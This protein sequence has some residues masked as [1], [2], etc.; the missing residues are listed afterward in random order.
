M[1]SKSKLAY[2]R[3]I[4]S[5]PVEEQYK[6]CLITEAGGKVQIHILFI[7]GN[8]FEDVMMVAKKEAENGKV[9][10]ILPEIHFKEKDAR[11][12]LLPGVKGQSNPDL[13]VDSSF[14][15]VEKTD[16]LENVG[17]RV[18][19]GYKQAN[20]VAVILNKPS[21]ETNFERLVFRLR[22][23]LE[24][25]ENLIIYNNQGKVL[26]LSIKLRRGN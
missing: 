7:K 13:L 16:K 5:K 20:N 4:Y 19:A 24:D 10:K 26:H 15:E 25:L 9:V 11:L 8:D 2:Q 6:T 17:K 1:I 22:N 18:R 23:D 3:F 21:E 14:I 12:K